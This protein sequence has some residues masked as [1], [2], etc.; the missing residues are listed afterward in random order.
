[1]DD[2]MINEQGMDKGD[3]K[4]ESH[5]NDKQFQ[6]KLQKVSSEIHEQYVP[7]S[8]SKATMVNTD[9]TAVQT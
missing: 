3:E 7:P 4:V 6:Y 8:E 5:L 9:S 1:M 2:Q